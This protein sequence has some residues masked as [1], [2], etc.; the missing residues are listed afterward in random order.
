M[1]DLMIKNNDWSLRPWKQV[2]EDQLSS[3]LMYIPGMS[4]SNEAKEMKGMKGS[5]L[6]MSHFIHS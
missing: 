5:N 6:L 2:M 1:I 4:N 3:W